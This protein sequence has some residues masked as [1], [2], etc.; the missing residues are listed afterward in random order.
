MRRIG[1][2]GEVVGWEVLAEALPWWKFTKREGELLAAAFRKVRN[3]CYVVLLVLRRI[4]VGWKKV[5]RAS[6]LPRSY[7]ERRVRATKGAPT[8]YFAGS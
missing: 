7:F 6:C 1:S 2:F 4:M 8:K 3:P 5:W